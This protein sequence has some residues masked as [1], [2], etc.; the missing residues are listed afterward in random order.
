MRQKLI[1]AL[2][3]TMIVA[4]LLGASLT[5]APSSASADEHERSEPHEQMHTMMDTMMGTGF[6]ERMHAAMPGS[7]EMMEA[8][9]SG[10]PN[11]MNM[12]DG[13]MNGMDN[14]TR[15]EGER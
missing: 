7:E 14:T 2:G 6:S 3:G 8:C 11:M 10:M 4:G 5:L 15:R 9:A 12:M 1:L 13:M